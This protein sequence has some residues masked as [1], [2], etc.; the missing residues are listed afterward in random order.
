MFRTC[1]SLTCAAVVALL[2]ISPSSLWAQAKA[3][4][5]A[6]GARGVPINVSHAGVARLY[7]DLE[8]IFKLANEAPAFKTLKETLDVFFEGVDPKLPAV[9]QVYVRKGKFNIVMHTPTAGNPRLFRNNLRTLGITSRQTGA[10]TFMLGGVLNGFLKEGGNIAIVAEMKEDL[11]PLAG[12]LVAAKNKLDPSNH[13]FVASVINDA[14]QIDD[15][16]K[17]IEEVRKQVMPGLKKLKN[18]DDAKFELRKLTF[19]QK[20]TEIQQVY[21]E[22]ASISS[23]LDVTSAKKTLFSTTSLKA[24]PN[25]ELA[26]IIDGLANEPSYFANVPL[27]TTD[28]LSGMINLKLDQL[29]QKHMKNFLAQSRPLLLKELKEQEGNSEKTKQYSQIT[30]EIV[31]DVLEKCTADGLY[32]AFIDVRANSSGTHTSVSGVKVDGA[33]VKAGLQKLQAA[34]TVQLDTG[35]VGDVELHKVTLP[36]EFTELHNVYGKDLVMTVGT[37]PK[38][39][40]FAMGENAEAKLKEAIEK[41]GQAAPAPNNIVA[42]MHGRAL[43]WYELFDANRTKHKKGDAEARKEA[44]K[45]FKAGGDIF[46]YKME[47]VDGSLNLTLNLHEGILRYFGKVGAKITRENFDN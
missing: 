7:E 21:G 25:T 17:A 34:T 24:L 41:A 10:G 32:D 44:L 26:K 29:R 23:S 38:A 47:K 16:K 40:W 27:S 8:Y 28:P 33:I 19:D 12:G 4:P 35:K 6:A 18:E 45:A 9:F 1:F 30:T 15:R 43:I 46:E 39:A 11:M 31:F 3:A 20:L 13:D 14:A 2:L 37:S 36:N 22:A 42:S 5:A